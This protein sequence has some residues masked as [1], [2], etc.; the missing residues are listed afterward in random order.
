MTLPGTRWKHLAA[1]AAIVSVIAVAAVVLG[2]SLLGLGPTQPPPAGSGKVGLFHVRVW[3]EPGLQKNVTLP[4]AP[5]EDGYTPAGSH[6][7]QLA[8]ETRF[9][10]NLLLVETA[11]PIGGQAVANVT[12]FDAAN[13]T[14]EWGKEKGAMG[15]LTNVYA[16]GGH[17]TVDH[18]VGCS[19]LG[20]ESS[21]SLTFPV[22]L[23]LQDGSHVQTVTQLTIKKD[24][25]TIAERWQ[26]SATPT[27]PVTPCLEE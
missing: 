25:G 4:C 13:R 1:F 12:W 3:L 6:Y 18:E 19:Q 11:G 5:L 10:L 15:N 24:S 7:L 9:A 16:V 20:E 14:D 26:Y 2:P 27:C 23:V 8:N 21:Q 22:V 17:Q